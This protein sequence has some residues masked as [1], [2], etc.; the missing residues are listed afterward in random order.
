MME[1]INKKK[2]TQQ[3]VQGEMICENKKKKP[4]RERI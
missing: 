3:K 1:K 2:K 4:N